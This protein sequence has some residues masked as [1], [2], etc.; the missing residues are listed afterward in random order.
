MG[1]VISDNPL[2]NFGLNDGTHIDGRPVLRRSSSRLKHRV[3]RLVAM[4]SM[5]GAASNGGKNYKPL[6][7]SAFRD[8]RHRFFNA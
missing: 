4:G 1:Q 8:Q 3:H 2:C 6:S 7:S 5:S